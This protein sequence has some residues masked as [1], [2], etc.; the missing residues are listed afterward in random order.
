M[1]KSPY[2][3]RFNQVTLGAPDMAASIVFYQ[4]LGLTLIV[5][6]APRYVRFEFPKT[7]HGEPAT[8]SLH[9]V[10]LDWMPTDWPLIYFE[11][12]DLDAYLKDLKLTPL[13]PPKIQTYLW[14]EADLL[15]PAGNK[16]RL[17]QAGENRRYPPWR[18]D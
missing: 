1:T 2:N 14:R 7:S 4:S 18:V 13:A 12:D 5:D 10:K 16:I 11:V 17:Y 6:S 15:D 9:E 3:L 8:L